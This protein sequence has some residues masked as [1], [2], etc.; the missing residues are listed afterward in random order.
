MI[1]YSPHRW[2][3]HFFDVRGSMVRE[4]TIP[5]LLCTA[6]AAVVWAFSAYVDPR[7]GLTSTVHRLAGLALGLLLVFRTNSAYDRFWEGRTLWG[8]I[9]NASR[10]LGR[11]SKAFLKDDPELM[12]AIVRWTAAFPHAA[13]ERLRGKHG[14]GP[15]ADRLPPDE[16][17][18]ALRADHTPLAVTTRITELL[19]EAHRRGLISDI[20]LAHIAQNPQLLMDC[21][22]GCERI[23]TTPIP[24][25]Y[26]VHL[27]RAVVAYCVT[28]PFALVAEF[29]W[30]SIID[31]FL[32]SY[33]FF[34]IEEIGVEIEDPFGVDANDLPLD[35]FCSMIESN[36][37][38]LVGDEPLPEPSELTDPDAEGLPGQ[39]T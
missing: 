5:V 19:A 30:V 33:L 14:L 15:I 10:N 4:I 28:L 11:L 6:W 9:I 21:I 7:I 29:G 12:L 2:F 25:A 13:T 20:V 39:A 16:V 31:T 32:I 18:A 8:Q 22:G 27:R 17:A 3:S 34:G 37:L 36:L 23:H 35:N 38:D 24:F 26:M 1:N